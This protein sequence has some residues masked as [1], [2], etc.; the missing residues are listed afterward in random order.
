MRVYIAA[1]YSSDPIS[2]TVRAMEAAHALLDAGF[3]PFVP[4]LSHFLEKH[5]HRPY[6]DWMDLDF[7]WLR[8]SE[9]VLRLPGESPGA[10]EEVTLARALGIPVFESVEAL[11]AS[12]E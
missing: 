10:D 9:A 2:N 7:A 4:H 5:R 12:K 11:I 8:V 3:H 6:R 1:P